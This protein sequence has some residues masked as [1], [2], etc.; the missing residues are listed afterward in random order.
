MNLLR[1]TVL[2]SLEIKKIMENL[3]LFTSCKAEYSKNL[4]SI[5]SGYNATNTWVVSNGTSAINSDETSYAGIKSLK[6]SV[7]HNLNKII[8]TVTDTFSC[9]ING[10]YVFSFRLYEKVNPQFANNFNIKINF[11]KNN[12]FYKTC[13][14]NIYGDNFLQNKPDL[15]K[16]NTFATILEL[17]NQ[18]VLTWNYEFEPIVPQNATSVLFIDG[19]KLEFDDRKLNGQPT[20]YTEPQ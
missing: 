5:D 14:Y 12:I 9:L 20:F 17:N 19:L 11:F 8:S 2:T 7:P 10:N 13:F 1:L 3:I 6:V 15:A 16:W 18:D 4:L